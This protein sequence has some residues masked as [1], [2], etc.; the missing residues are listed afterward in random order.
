MSVSGSFQ[1]QSAKYA[2][3]KA[4]DLEQYN[5]KLNYQ[6][7]KSLSYE[8]F[9]RKLISGRKSFFTEWENN[10]FS[11]KSEY[12]F[13]VAESKKQ[14]LIKLFTDLAELYNE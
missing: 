12:R 10:E 14:P 6:Q 5:E 9:C 3:T 8:D 4:N 2:V 1:F 7:I 13:A 11:K